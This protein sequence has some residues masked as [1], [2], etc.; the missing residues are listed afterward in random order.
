LIF[1]WSGAKTIAPDS[2]RWSDT[3]ENRAIISYAS[4]LSWRSMGA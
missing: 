1:C 2:A 4:Y 3:G